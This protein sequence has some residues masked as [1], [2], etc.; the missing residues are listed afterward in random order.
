MA[1][2]SSIYLVQKQVPD[3]RGGP[4]SWPTIAAFTVKHECQRYLKENY[5]TYGVVNDD[6]E[7]VKNFRGVRIQ[8]LHDGDP[9]RG[10]RGRAKVIELEH[11]EW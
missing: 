6:V 5:I 8:I 2:A 1:R 3:G 4:S 7:P 11:Q 10:P 9:K